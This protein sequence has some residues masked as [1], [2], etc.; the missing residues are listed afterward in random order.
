RDVDRGTRPDARLHATV[1]PRREDVGE[2]GEVLDLLH[3]LFLVGEFDQVEI[4][5]G[6]H[7]VFRLSADPSAHVHIAV[8]RARTGGIHG[9]ADARFA[10]AA[11]AAAP[12]GDVERDGDQVADVQHLHVAALL[13]DFAGDLVSE[14]QSLRRRR[15]AANH[16]LVRT[17]DVRRNHF[18]DDAV[19]SVLPAERVRFA[20][21]HLQLR[22]RYGLNLYLTGFDICYSTICWHTSYLLLFAPIRNQNA[23]AP[24]SATAWS[25]SP[26]PPL[27]PTA[28]TTFPFFFS[29]TPPAKIMILPLFDAWIPKHCP[30]DCEWAARSL[31]EMS[32][33]REVYA[34][35]WEISML[36]IHAP[37]MRTCATIFPPSSATAIFIGCPISVAFFSAAAIILRAS[38]KLTIVARSPFVVF[39][40]RPALFFSARARCG[41]FYRTRV[42]TVLSRSSAQELYPNFRP[43]ELVFRRD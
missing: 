12:A 21:G 35:F 19:R 39:S 36:P 17:A 29:G 38:A 9:Q 34:F 32:K 37:S 22:V 14:D 13:D 30:P 31:V 28:P 27:T 25:W 42:R 41:H 20:L 1:E 11:I 26:D 10:F 23:A 15:P 33:A 7:D 5:V 43:P 6:D 40:R 8:G 3:R 2:Q 4:G 16:V 24:A 18:Q